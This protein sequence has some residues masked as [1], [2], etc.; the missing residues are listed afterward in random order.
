MTYR[1]SA[2][3]AKEVSPALQRWEVWKRDLSPVGTTED[4][5]SLSRVLRGAV[6]TRLVIPC[7]NKPSRERLG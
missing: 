3:G 1:K 4:A 7:S 6:A 5:G 2:V